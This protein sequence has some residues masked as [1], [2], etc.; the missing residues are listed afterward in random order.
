MLPEKQ[1]RLPT[2]KDSQHM[3]DSSVT[4]T[5]KRE[6]P[7]KVWRKPKAPTSGPCT[8]EALPEREDTL[9]TELQEITTR[10]APVG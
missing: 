9:Q 7:P 4:V 8:G 3:V 2:D 10:D 1:H 5:G 6:M